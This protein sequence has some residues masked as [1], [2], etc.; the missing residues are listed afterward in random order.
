MSRAIRIGLAAAVAGALVFL[1]ARA[2]LPSSE[3]AQPKL[4]Y[5]PHAAADMT[6]GELSGILRAVEAVNEST[7][8]AELAAEGQKLFRSSALAKRGE[9][10]QTCHTLAGANPAIGTTPHPTSAGDFTGPRDP[11][12]LWGVRETAPY[13]WIG[14]AKTLEE[15][16]TRTVANHFKDESASPE[17]VAAVVA[18]LRTLKPPVTAFDQG[19]MSEQQLRGEEVFQGKGGCIGCH[20]GPQFTDNAF[21][22]IIPPNPNAGPKDDCGVNNAANSRC[23]KTDP[24]GGPSPFTGAFNTPTLRNISESGPYFHDGSANSLK[25]VVDFYNTQSA[26]APLALQPDEISDLVE[27]LKTL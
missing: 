10:C 25:A 7:P 26:I 4:G 11:P 24:A 3:E 17:R 27:Y 13:F 18:Y 8:P 1:A 12:S 16:V 15:V 2:V 5:D 19:T 21:H 23:P 9:A 14:D 20:G 6:P 22:I